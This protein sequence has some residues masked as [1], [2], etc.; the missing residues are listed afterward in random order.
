MVNGKKTSTL[1]RCGIMLL[2]KKG[3]NNNNY[4]LKTMTIIT[5]YNPAILNL[6]L[7]LSANP[8]VK[9]VKHL[10]GKEIQLIEVKAKIQ[11]YLTGKNQFDS[12]Y[13]ILKNTLIRF[14]DYENNT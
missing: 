6:S 11:F 9:T 10:A 2:L 14:D 12:D 13:E 3:N 4:I 8:G 5:R 7:L 1:Q